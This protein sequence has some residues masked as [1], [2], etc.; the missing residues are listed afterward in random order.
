MDID[1]HFLDTEA[2][3][4]GEAPRHIAGRFDEEHAVVPSLANVWSGTTTDDG[5]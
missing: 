4:A 2:R 5:A 3:I 1:V